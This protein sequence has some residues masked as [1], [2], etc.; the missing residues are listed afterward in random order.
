[1]P[2]SLTGIWI[3]TTRD[4]DASYTWRVVQRGDD[5]FIYATFNEQTVPVYYYSGVIV[6]NVL[7]INGI[8]TSIAVFIDAEHFVLPGWEDK[9]DML[10][11]RE[12]LA[13]LAAPTAWARYDAMIKRRDQL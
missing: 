5:V 13:E 4:E 12:G 9:R 6:A 1:M 10:F 8:P 11:C 2:L 3:G 7:S